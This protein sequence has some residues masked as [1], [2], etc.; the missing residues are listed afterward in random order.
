MTRAV[1]V[2][3]GPNGL[4]AATV[5]AES[6]VDVHVIEAHEE[7]GGGARNSVPL[8]P[9]LVQDHCA[10]VHPMA[11]GSSYLADLDLPGIEW[12]RADIDCAHPLDGGEAML[13]RQSIA[14]TAAGLGRDGS[15]WSALFGAPARSF[16]KL[17]EDIM[18]PLVGIPRHPFALARFGAVA[19]L[20]PTWVARAFRE[21]GTRA[22]FLGVAAHAFQ[23]LNIPLVTG[24]GAGIITAGHAVGWP[25]VKGGTGAMTSAI[26]ARLEGLGVTFETGRRIRDRAELPPHD[27]AMFDLHP[28]LVADILGDDMPARAR[29]AYTRF[30]SGPAAFKVEFAVEGGVPWEAEGV[31]RAGTVHLGGSAVEV[32]ASEREV[33]EGRMPARPFVLVGQQAAA[34]PQ[35]AVGSIQPLY[36][37]AHV[38]AHFEGD[39]TA[40]ILA[41]IERFAPGFQERIIATRVISSTELSRENPNYIGGDILT[42]AKSPLQFTLGPRVTA[43]P[44]DTGVP[45]SYICS[46]ATPPGPGVHGMCGVNAAQ[47]ALRKLTPVPARSTSITARR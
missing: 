1:V 22:L 10:A 31:D 18:R 41:Q 45:G 12:A 34:D 40:Q 16:G 27:I 15:R 28:H 7:L 29:A 26:I 42:G 32:V 44:Y 9:G 46:A 36:A 2:G 19:A 38:P 6:G 17:S 8:L 25:V 39:A 5:L 33:A 24:I 30:R 21:E 37:Y 43:H 20:P 4:A 23:R 35:R 13:L 14:D 3:S 47:R 11:A